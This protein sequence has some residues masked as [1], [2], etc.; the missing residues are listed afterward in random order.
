MQC[1]AA[2]QQRT[3]LYSELSLVLVPELPCC[4]R[5]ALV[6]MHCLP[7]NCLARSLAFRVT[8]TPSPVVR[9]FHQNTPLLESCLPRLN[10]L[11][12]MHVHT[13]KLP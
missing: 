3:Y 7:G 6:K 13:L 8:V 2:V 5:R 12:L 1:T 11:E 9:I 4:H 10:L